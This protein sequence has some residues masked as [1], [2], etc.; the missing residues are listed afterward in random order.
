VRIRLQLNSQHKSNTA[1]KI[2]IRFV[3]KG[4]NSNEPANIQTHNTH[5]LEQF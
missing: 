1:F 3:D 5:C 2:D 4:K